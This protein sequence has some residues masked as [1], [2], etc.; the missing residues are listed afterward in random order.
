MTD[1]AKEKSCAVVRA[2]R[3]ISPKEPVHINTEADRD[4]V[5]TAARAVINEHRDVLRALARRWAVLETAFVL[6]IRDEILQDEPGFADP[7]FGLFA[8]TIALSTKGWTTYSALLPYAVAIACGHIFNDANKRLALVTARTYLK[9]QGIDLSRNPSLEDTMVGV[10]EGAIDAEAF[11]DA[12]A[13]I[14][15]V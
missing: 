12:L 14:P 11:A 2:R 3:M 1:E 5:V 8:L 6:Q 15:L 9:L 13:C 7:G 10:E 4:R